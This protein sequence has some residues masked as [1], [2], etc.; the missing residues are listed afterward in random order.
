MNHKSNLKWILACTAAFTVLLTGCGASSSDE[1]I[2]ESAEPMSY[3]AA[4][5]EAE[6]MAAVEE[7]GGLMNDESKS[8]E[9]NVPAERKIVKHSNLSLETKEFDSAL[10][11]LV[12]VVESAGGYLES[13]TT[14]GRSLEDEDNDYYTRSAQLNARIPADKI[15][16]VTA[17]V[18]ELCNIVSRNDSIDDITDTYFDTEAH[19]NVLELQEKRLLELLSKAEKLEDVISLETAL[20]EVRYQ[21]ESLT[22]SIKR[23]DSQVTYSYLGL[24][25]QEVGEYNNPISTPKNFSDRIS[26]SFSRSITHVKNSVQGVILFVV[27]TAP[28]ALFWGIVFA[29]IILV[30][31]KISSRMVVRKQNSMIPPKHNQSKDHP[32]SQ[33]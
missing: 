10:S 28:V 9:P 26:T 1:A 15:D 24:Y 11:K 19:L 23:M 16:E 29:V 13:Q 2:V 30:V 21:I 8:I 31:Y 32:D 27:E 4:A 25:L 20:S 12:E 33:A 18:G 17:S 3:A 6:Y 7:N 5:D 14:N 22:A